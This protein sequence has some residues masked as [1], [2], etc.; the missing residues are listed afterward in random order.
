MSPDS[1]CH[2]LL[3]SLSLPQDICLSFLSNTPVPAIST[4]GNTI[5]PVLTQNTSSFWNPS[6]ALCF[7]RENISLHSMTAMLILDGSV[8]AL[9]Q[10]PAG[11]ELKFTPLCSSQASHT[12]RCTTY[13][14]PTLGRKGC[15]QY[16]TPRIVPRPQQEVT[17]YFP[18]VEQL[19]MGLV[20]GF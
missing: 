10:A 13:F 7:P 3:P 8:P 4:C 19:N 6:Q 2:I 12:S 11:Q 15:Y 18:A 5:L 20:P 17:K 16:P 1:L 9:V 14:V